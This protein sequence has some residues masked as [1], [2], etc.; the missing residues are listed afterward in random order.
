MFELY[1]T[2]CIA[3]WQCIIEPFTYFE[4]DLYKCP[5]LVLLLIVLIC[6]HT[7][8]IRLIIY[9]LLWRTGYL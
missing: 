2:L 3:D 1:H 6:C 9:L 5:C 8:V 4:V 7:L